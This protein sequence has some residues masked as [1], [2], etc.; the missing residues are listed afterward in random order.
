MVED[1]GGDYFGVGDVGVDVVDLGDQLV[2][3]FVV[4]YQVEVVGCYQCVDLQ[5]VDFVCCQV[6]CQ[7]GVEQVGVG[8]Y[9]QGSEIESVKREE[10]LL[11]WIFGFV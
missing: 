6:Q 11:Y 9:Q 5:V 2:I 7:V 3:D 4:Q 10:N 8:E 1:C